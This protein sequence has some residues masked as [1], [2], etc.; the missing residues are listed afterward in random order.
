MCLA[1]YLHSINSN[2]YCW[3]S[4]YYNQFVWE[5]V[6]QQCPSLCNTMD[7][8]A[9]QVPLHGIL[10]E[11]ILEWV[12]IPFSK[13]SSWPRDQT[14]VSCIAGGF[15]TMWSTQEAH[16]FQ[17]PHSFITWEK[18]HIEPGLAMSYLV[19]MNLLAFSCHGWFIKMNQWMIHQ[20]EKQTEKTYCKSGVWKWGMLCISGAVWGDRRDAGRGSENPFA[21]SG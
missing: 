17:F 19:G 20:D 18:Q 3:C 13:R 9:R 8:I 5:L 16:Y 7:Y 11:N 21:N 2:Y 10:Q 6:A 14:W 1:Q 4:C 12:D 15:L